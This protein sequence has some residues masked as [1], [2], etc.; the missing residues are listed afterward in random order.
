MVCLLLFSLPPQLSPWVVPVT[1]DVDFSRIFV[2]SC[3][4]YW[5][6]L[7]IYSSTKKGKA[8]LRKELALRGRLSITTLLPRISIGDVG[9]C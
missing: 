6:H 7:P 5:A 1:I 9:C 3:E 2:R 8:A 4:I